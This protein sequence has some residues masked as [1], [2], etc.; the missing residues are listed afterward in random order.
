MHDRVLAKPA[1]KLRLVRAPGLIFGVANIFQKAVGAARLPSNA[2]FPAKMDHAMREV[3]PALLGNQP[4]HVL[5]DS[6]RRRRLG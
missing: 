5:F 4:H 1:R 2:S 6:F 3:D